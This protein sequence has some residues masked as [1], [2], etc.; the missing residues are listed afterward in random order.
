MAGG[1][2]GGSNS[3][4]TV[5]TMVSGD[6]AIATLNANAGELKG[7]LGV[8]GR[9]AAREGGA[10]SSGRGGSGS[11]TELH[12]RFASDTKMSMSSAVV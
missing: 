10:G 12:V 6:A 3:T 2:G 11:G 7:M 5:P 8:A 9:L 1:N 4:D